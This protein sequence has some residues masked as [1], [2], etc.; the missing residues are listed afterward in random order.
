VAGEGEHGGHNLS[1]NCKTV[2]ALRTVEGVGGGWVK[3]QDKT[4]TVAGGGQ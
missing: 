3:G 4:V 1:N 2:Q